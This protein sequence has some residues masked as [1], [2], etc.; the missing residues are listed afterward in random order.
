MKQWVLPTF[1]ALMFVIIGIAAIGGFW[2]E[3][4]EVK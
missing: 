4:S 2:L 3:L 1:F